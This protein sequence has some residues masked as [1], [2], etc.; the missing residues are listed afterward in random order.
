[1][2]AQRWLCLASM[3]VIGAWRWGNNWLKK[4]RVR[5]VSRLYLGNPLLDSS[6]WRGQSRYGRMREETIGLTLAPMSEATTNP[7]AK[8]RA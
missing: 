8:S 1:M 7:L 4:K 2:V 6:H 3:L 5:E